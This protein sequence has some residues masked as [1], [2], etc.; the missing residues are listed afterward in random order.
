[1]ILGLRSCWCIVPISEIKV[2]NVLP[3]KVGLFPYCHSLPFGIEAASEGN[4]TGVRFS[5]FKSWLYHLLI[6]ILG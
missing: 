4:S 3:I 5:G 2:I 1:M 6:R